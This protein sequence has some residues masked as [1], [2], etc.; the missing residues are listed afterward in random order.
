MGREVHFVDPNGQWRFG[1]DIMYSGVPR[2]S[3]LNQSWMWPL[4]RVTGTVPTIGQ[5]L[6]VLGALQGLAG[7]SLCDDSFSNDDLRRMTPNT[8]WRKSPIVA[9]H[10]VKGPDV[11][12]APPGISESIAINPPQHMGTD[13]RLREISMEERVSTLLARGRLTWIER[14]R[15]RQTGEL[16]EI[17]WPNAKINTAANTR[18]R[19]R[20]PPL[21]PYG[22]IGD[23]TAK[24]FDRYLGSSDRSESNS[25]GDE[26]FT[27]HFAWPDRPGRR[28]TADLSNWGGKDRWACN[29]PDFPYRKVRYAERAFDAGIYGC[30]FEPYLYEFLRRLYKGMISYDHLYAP[31][32]FVE[33]VGELLCRR[34]GCPGQWDMVG[35]RY[36]TDQIMFRACV[37]AI[38]RCADD[39]VRAKTYWVLTGN[40]YR[41]SHWSWGGDAQTGRFSWAVDGTQYNHGDTPRTYTTGW[42]SS[43]FDRRIDLI[44]EHEKFQLLTTGIVGKTRSQYLTCWKRWAQFASCVGKSP[45]IFEL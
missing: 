19:I 38:L 23:V 32:W 1:R 8:L 35:R 5:R 17:A 6:V 14:L 33:T 39:H 34:E 25:V 28:Y 29:Y 31:P 3:A 15:T 11:D 22:A 16:G 4:A 36:G 18:R 7:I 40:A 45:L 2:K 43:E 12:I 24:E 30:P 9:S 42:V 37:H 27:A 21:G 10:G 41:V 44:L 20:P 13:G 26:E